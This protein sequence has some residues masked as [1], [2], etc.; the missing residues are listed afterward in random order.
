MTSRN[1]IRRVNAVVVTLLLVLA[2]VPAHAFPI[3]EG[4]S[5]GWSV[6]SL[7]EAFRSLVTGVWQE[8]GIMIDPD[9]LTAGG[10]EGMS[11]DPN[12]LTVDEGIM[13]DPNG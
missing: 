7:W 9:G 10:D 1:L 3:A 11:I 2:A 13:I 4:A 5:A 12:G 6:G 8:E